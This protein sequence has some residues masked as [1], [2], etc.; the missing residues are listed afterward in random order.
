VVGIAFFVLAAAISI[1]LPLALPMTFIESHSVLPGAR[2]GVTG[3][4]VAGFVVWEFVYYWLHRAEHRF[5]LLWRLLHQL[6]HSPPRVDAA[7]FSYS[8]PLDIV[9]ATVLSL[10]VT[11]GLLGLDPRASALVSMYV[12]IAALVQHAN[13]RTPRWLEWF[14][15]RP[16]A[17]A[18][19][20]E[21]GQH[22]GNYA[23]WPLIDRLFGTYRAP[24]QGPLQ[25]G[26]DVPR[27]AQWLAMLGFRDVHRDGP[28]MP[29]HE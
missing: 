15:Q 18:R 3:G 8:H 24:A 21:Y 23:D 10:L 20:H 7:G 2:L 6:H 26:F 14:M 5:D 9:V 1:G 12:S 29:H 25:Y 13:I 4:F 16:E 22:A 11:V 19:H 27:A 28:P 17:H